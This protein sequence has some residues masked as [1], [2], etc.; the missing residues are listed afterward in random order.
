MIVSFTFRVIE[1]NIKP[2]DVHREIVCVGNIGRRGGKRQKVRLACE[3]V[4]SSFEL[5]KL[6]FIDHMV[7]AIGHSIPIKARGDIFV[8][9]DRWFATLVGRTKSP[10]TTDMIDVSVSKDHRIKA[11][12]RP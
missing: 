11:V 10:T 4:A 7:V 8:P 6:A 12:L 2:T 3:V 9:N 1:L 5:T